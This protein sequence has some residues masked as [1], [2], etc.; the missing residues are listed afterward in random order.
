MKGLLAMVAAVFLSG[1]VSAQRFLPIGSEFKDAVF[2]PSRARITEPAFFPFIPDSLT[3][4]GFYKNKPW[5]VKRYS[6]FGHYVYQRE[7]IELKDTAVGTLWITPLIDLS[8]GMQFQDTNPK[9]YQN[10]RGL[11]A[12]GLLG[13]RVFFTTSFY[14]NQAIFADYF[15]DYISQRG[16]QYR[17][18]IDSN[19]YTSNAVVPGSARTKPFKT[20][21][22]DYAYATGMVAIKLIP[23]KWTV[24]WGNQ[25]FFIG[26]GHRSLL[27]SDNS[28]GLMNLRSVFRFS[29]KW[30]WQFVRARGLNLLRRPEAHNGEAYYEP[31]AFSVATLYFQPT[32]TFTIG[33]FEGGKWYRGDS[34]TKKP[35]QPLYYLPVPGVAAAQEAIKDGS[36]FALTGID[37][38]WWL[39]RK[40]E[41]FDGRTG[42]PGLHH[43]LI[44]GQF[45][46]TPSQAKSMVYQLGVRFFP[47]KIPAM[48]FQ[49]EYNH[50][51][52][53][54]YQSAVTRLNYSNYNLPVAHPSAFAFDEV[55]VRA[56]WQK[57]YWF[58]RAQTNVFF[59]Q[60]ENETLLMPI[61]KSDL[62]TSRQVINQSVEFG[63][64]FNR[65]YG[66]EAFTSFRYR[67][68][69]GDNTYNEGAWLM[70]GIRTA[71]N[72]HYSD[73]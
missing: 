36:T 14:E 50:A 52:D 67:Y 16:E 26:S 15:A 12:E 8:F 68:A 17:S 13:K 43:L 55:V 34:V 39:L 42:V 72:N 51:D 24:T 25:P 2:A 69:K 49:L 29:D 73:F 61:L 64:C 53:N 38:S 62:A 11:R 7:L 3:S 10:T 70:L 20:T 40:T 30:Q 63:H 35:V 41:T 58:V 57:K 1:I 60:S 28:V 48:R 44:Y 21:G 5:D 23:Q 31:T 46:L 6:T 45:A 18:Y 47:R 65:S 4:A 33:L 71:L 22:F 56:S 27:W 66:F 54:A 37:F 19:Y 32:E 59:R 9:R